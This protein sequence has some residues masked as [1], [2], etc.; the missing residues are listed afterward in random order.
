[1][2][3]HTLLGELQRLTHLE[4]LLWVMHITKRKDGGLSSSFYRGVNWVSEFQSLIS[5]GDTRIETGSQG[6]ANTDSA[7]R[8]SFPTVLST[9]QSRA[10]SFLG[11][12]L[13]EL[14]HCQASREAWWQVRKQSRLSLLASAQCKPLK[15]ITK[16]HWLNAITVRSVKSLSRVQLFATPWTVARQ[17]PLPR[18]F[19]RQEY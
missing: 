4:G 16:S 11:A 15:K 1:M 19:S 13:K 12:Y 6:L 18:E 9:L 7:T 5:W 10:Q 3:V 8:G 17:A 2:V 14:L